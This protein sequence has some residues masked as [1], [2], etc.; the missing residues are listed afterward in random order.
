[1]GQKIVQ[2]MARRL[3]KYFRK[4]AGRLI[5]I[6]NL[7]GNWRRCSYQKSKEKSEKVMKSRK[8]I[9][10]FTLV[11]LTLFGV[12]ALGQTTSG[13]ISGTTMDPQGQVVPGA[14]VRVKNLGTG[15]SREVS[16]NSVGNY[17]IAGLQPGRYEVQVEAK[18]FASETRNNVALSVAEEIVVNFSL[19]VGVAKENVTVNVETVGVETTGSTLSGMVDEKKI[20]DLPLNGRGIA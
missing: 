19:K 18:G 8:R 1:D 10:L 16:S 13:T 5:G 7:F 11:C 15:A 4:N 17:R 14:I 20:R 12:F 3:S 9:M 6:A 2:K